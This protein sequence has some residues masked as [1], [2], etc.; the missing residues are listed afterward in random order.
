MLAPTDGDQ[1]QSEEALPIGSGAAG[2]DAMTQ[3]FRVRCRT[4]PVHLHNAVDS[5]SEIYF[6]QIHKPSRRR[7]NYKPKAAR[8]GKKNT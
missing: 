8:G 7:V 2:H 6:R 4:T 5:K 3:D 1:A